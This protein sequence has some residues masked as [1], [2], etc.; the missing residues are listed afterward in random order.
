MLKFVYLLT[1]G[2]NCDILDTIC[3]TVWDIQKERRY[4]PYGYE[5]LQEYLEKR[6]RSKGHTL[7]S[8]ADALGWATG[9]LTSAARGQFRMSVDRCD[10]LAKF[11]G[12]DPAIC[13]TLAGHMEPPPEGDLVAAIARHA[14]SL[15]PNLQ[16][17]LLNLAEWLLERQSQ[18][19]DTL[20]QDQLYV[21]LPDGSGVAVDVGGDPLRLSEGE[22]RVAIRTA[23]RIAMDRD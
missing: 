23:I 5:D 22:L 10:Q 21:E 4:M 19:R 15:K 13:K 18:A 8:L 20:L 17:T 1:Q 9:Y 3:E 14:N 12:D 7:S 2:T 16:R 11:L 6:S